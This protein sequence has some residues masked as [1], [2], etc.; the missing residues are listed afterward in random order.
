MDGWSSLT[1]L[2]KRQNAEKHRKAKL[3]YDLQKKKEGFLTNDETEFEFDFPKISQFEMERVKAKIRADLR[4]QRIKNRFI[5]LLILIAVITFFAWL[6]H[7]KTGSI[8]Q[9]LQ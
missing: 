3:R 4:K 8:T 7:T 1:T 5:S 2:I 6:I 9:F